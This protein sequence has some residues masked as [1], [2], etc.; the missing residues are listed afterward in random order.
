MPYGTLRHSSR[1]AAAPHP[2]CLS[3]NQGAAG[4]ALSATRCPWARSSAQAV[5]GP[6]KGGSQ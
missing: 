2:P 5:L 3:R 6:P 4:T 1:A